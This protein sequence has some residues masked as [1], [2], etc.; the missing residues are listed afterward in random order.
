MI[1]QCLHRS[2]PSFEGFESFNSVHQISVESS[3]WERKFGG[4]LNKDISAREAE[5]NRKG[6]EKA[7]IEDRAN[8]I[9]ASSGRF[10]SGV[11]NIVF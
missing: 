8:S 1:I 5:E 10:I 2:A 4:D 11:T 7:A 6:R 3:R 9:E